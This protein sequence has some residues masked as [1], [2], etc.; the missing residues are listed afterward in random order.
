MKVIRLSPEAQARHGANIKVIV[1]YTDVAGIGASAAG[2]LQVFPA[3]GSTGMPAGTRV[4]NC[5]FNLTT[6]FDFSDAGIT[7]LTAELGDGADPNRLITSTELAVDGTEILYKA[8]GA[9][10]QPYVYLAADA[11]DITFTA[12]NGGSPLLSE[13]TS[14]ELEVYMNITT[15]D[16]LEAPRGG[17]RS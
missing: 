11:I 2:V 9:V 6:A 4:S 15:E 8:E 7:S 14:G 10:T 16:D 17:N 13:C 5:R 1:S 12:A 3:S